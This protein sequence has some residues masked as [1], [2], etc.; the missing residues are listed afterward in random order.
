MRLTESAQVLLQYA[1]KTQA[2]LK[3]TETEMY[4]LKTEQVRLNFRGNLND[5][6]LCHAD[7]LR[8]LSKEVSRYS[9]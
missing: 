4:E 6:R 7:H 5:S 1:L 9:T 8:C 3:S 2:L